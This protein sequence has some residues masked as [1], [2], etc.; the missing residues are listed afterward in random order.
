M[1]LKQS[2]PKKKGK[3]NNLQL[4]NSTKSISCTEIEN[5]EKEKT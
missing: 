3:V 5:K 2:A 4:S 1:K